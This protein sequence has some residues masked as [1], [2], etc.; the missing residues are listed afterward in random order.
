MSARLTGAQIQLNDKDLPNTK[1]EG[2]VVWASTDKYPAPV[3]SCDV[4]NL[5][6]V[7]GRS[8]V[9]G[10]VGLATAASL[11]S[12]NTN[13]SDGLLQG[14]LNKVIR[15]ASD[16]IKLLPAT[17]TT[18]HQASV[19]PADPE[20]GFVVDGAYTEGETTQYAPY[21]GGFV[22]QAQAAFLGEDQGAPGGDDEGEKLT[23]LT[24][25]GLR[26]V[27]G[28]LYAGGFVGLGD[29]GA[30]AQVGG[31]GEDGSSTTTILDELLGSL[32]DDVAV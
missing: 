13:A 21:S 17:V 24:V 32:L 3:A 4:R 22:G 31:K 20:W 16:L 10:Y 11:A 28:G 14:I 1:E 23:N 19:S 2:S 18:I 7:S 15:S 5:R 29:V 8:S 26:Q 9:G 6:R 27:D 12:V 25:T 30:V